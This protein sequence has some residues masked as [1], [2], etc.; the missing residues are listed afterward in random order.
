[1]KKSLLFLTLINVY[2]G[3][4]QTVDNLFTMVSKIDA[5]STIR[6]GTFNPNI[7]FVS[8]IGT[9]LSGNSFGLSGGSLNQITNRFNLVGGTS[10]IS[11]NLSDGT[12]VNELP[13]NSPFAGVTYFTNVKYNYTDNTLYGLASNFTND[14]T[15]V[16]MYFAKLDTE[17]GNLTAISQS[18]IGDGYQ[19]AGTS[20]N[21]SMMVYYFITNSMIRGIDLYNGQ[22]F[23]SPTIVYSNPNDFNFTNFTYNCYDDTIYGLVTEDTQIPN[24][25]LPY[26]MNIYEMRLGKINPNTGQVTHIS[27]TPL[28]TSF[29]S[30]NA[31][32]TIDPISNTFYYCDGDNVYGISLLTGLIVSTTALTYEDGTFINFMTNYNNCLNSVVTRS[33]PELSLAENQLNTKT[34]VYPNP[35]KDNLII[36]S[37]TTID[38][39]EVFDINGRIVNVTSING[40]NLN[41]QNLQNGMYFLKI[42]SNGFVDYVKF[43]KD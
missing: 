31:S 18:S 12:I 29:Y 26:P 5:V 38:K 14:N 25:N 11:F 33:N 1:M 34:R 13:I 23:S 22:I 16:G 7:G 42:I 9:N 8:N 24:P 10:T 3:C 43:I 4:A 39:V 28:P 15:F 40:T 21:P 35:T 32:S 2:F 20:I 6:L 37:K 36:D 17:T 41:V 27:S 30:A 19:Y